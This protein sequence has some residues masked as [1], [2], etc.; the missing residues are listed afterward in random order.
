[1]HSD[2][3]LHLCK[4]GSACHSHGPYTRRHLLGLDDLAWIVCGACF[5]RVEAWVLL[6]A[7]WHYR[8]PK[9]HCAL[10]L[11]DLPG[12]SEFGLQTLLNSCKLT[13]PGGW[14]TCTTTLQMPNWCI[15]ERS[16]KKFRSI[17]ISTGMV[18]TKRIHTVQIKS[19][20]LLG[21]TR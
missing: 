17:P 11:S 7:I 21:F 13:V 18:P 2:L 4:F 8:I 1:M 5:P 16:I 12:Q 3:H 6:M 9:T 19:Y 14:I 15:P 20:V 10:A